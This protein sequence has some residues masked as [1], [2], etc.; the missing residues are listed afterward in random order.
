MQEGQDYVLRETTPTPPLENIDPKTGAILV[1]LPGDISIAD[2]ELVKI[3]KLKVGA[4]QQGGSLY[5]V[6]FK[7]DPEEVAKFWASNFGPANIFQNKV[8]ELGEMYPGQDILGAYMSMGRTGMNFAQH[9]AD[10]N[11]KAIKS[12]IKAGNVKQEDIDSFNKMIREGWSKINQKTGER[13]YFKYPDFAGI[14]KTGEAYAQMMR[15]PEL[16]KWFND[17]MK[18]GKETVPRGLP[19]GIDI[20]YAISEPALRNLEHSLVGYSVGK[21]QPGRELIAPIDHATYSHGIPG[22]AVGRLSGHIPAR[23]AFSDA[24]NLIAETKRPQDFTGTIQKVFPHQI[25]DQQWQDEVGQYLQYLKSFTGKKKGGLVG[26]S[27]G[28]LPKTVKSGKVGG[29][30]V[31]RNKHG[32]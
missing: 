6:P 32:N 3:G 5:G 28:K 24:S 13:E 7:D 26:I 19:S 20:E 17:R 22:R 25:V 31:L 27:L 2:K 11:L 14:E 15:D 12:A 4:Q 1:G 10:A 30:S 18:T 9:F 23:I 16:R 8:T 21:M 29:L